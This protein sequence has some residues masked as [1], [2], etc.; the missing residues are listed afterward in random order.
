M[1]IVW[2]AFSCP[3]LPPSFTIKLPRQPWVH[4]PPSSARSPAR[5]NPGGFLK[6]IQCQ[7]LYLK[8]T[9]LTQQRKGLTH[10][11]WRAL[12]HF[13]RYLLLNSNLQCLN[14]FPLFSIKNCYI[15]AERRRQWQEEQVIQTQDRNLNIR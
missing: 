3:A 1:L 5:R 14:H 11:M 2:V 12:Y 4:F 8:R 9:G 7:I 15:Q 10:R 6:V 13:L